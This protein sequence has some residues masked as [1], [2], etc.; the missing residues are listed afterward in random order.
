MLRVRKLV[1]A[2]AAASALTS[3][4]A[5]ALGLGEIALK[6]ALDQPLEAEIELLDVRGLQV[7]ELRSALASVEEFGKVG[8][9]RPYFLTGLKFTPV[10]QANGRSV[11]RVTSDKPVREPYLNFLVEVLWP[12]GRL[13]REYTV[14]L[15]P[16]LYAPAAAAALPSLPVATVAAP[17]PAAQ[18]VQRAAPVSAPAPTP[19]PVAAAR[20][21]LSAPVPPRQPQAAP[22]VARP[23]PVLRAEAAPASVPAS[24]RYRTGRDDTLWK[25]AARVRPSAAV[26]VH[27]TML[28]LQELNP[29]AFV[30]GN[31]NRLKAGQV[32]RL[33]DEQQIRGRSQA[34]ALA[35]V[36]R[37]NVAWR[38]GRGQPAAVARQLDATGRAQPAEPAT[39]APATDKLRLLSADSGTATRGSDK[40]AA[41]GGAGLTDKLALAEEQLATASREN[42]ELNERLGELQSQLD[43]LQRLIELKNAQLARL[44]GTQGE[45]EA[46][47]PPAG[48][49][50]TLAEVAAAPPAEGAAATSPAAAA[51]PAAGAATVAESEPAPGEAAAASAPVAEPAKAAAPDAA[52]MPSAEAPQLLDEL[53][54]NPNLLAAGGGALALL[55]ALGLIAARRRAQR[56][57]SLEA[58]DEP[59][60]LAG[61]GALSALDSAPAVAGAAV[62]AAEDRVL[63]EAEQAIAYGRFTQAAELLRA[64]LDEQPQ[65]SDLRLKLMEVCAE[66]GDRDGFVREEA[67]LRE[68]GGA[69]TQVEQLRS[70]YPSMPAFAAA[71]MA[72]AGVAAAAAEPDA[73]AELDEL[74]LDALSFEMPASEVQ[75]SSDD[76]P[77]AIELTLDDLQ[78]D[79][80]RELAPGG[81]DADL[82][83]DGDAAAPQEIDF[84]LDL[85]ALMLDDNPQSV[86]AAAGAAL[87]PEQVEPELPEMAEPL[88]LDIELPVLAEESAVQETLAGDGL[89]DLQAVDAELDAAFDAFMAHAAQADAMAPAPQ[90]G[91]AT[92][93]DLQFDLS[94]APLGESDLDLPTDADEAATKL[95]LARVYLDMGD[96]EGARDIL[97]EVLREGSAAQQQE[98]RE[99]IGR[100]T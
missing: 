91:R 98:A 6:S 88:S 39:L 97:D 19:A 22:P 69:Q 13:L 63:A 27:Q 32:L 70:R 18:P 90:S 85:D 35:E 53:L 28:A 66:M 41:Q 60:E 20:P 55:L 58:D 67:E 100:M 36:E 52:S 87:L 93:D 1:L 31:I 14:L 61:V 96:V 46:S 10:V 7:A 24:D 30:G 57:A 51:R 23:A 80:E 8:I 89:D 84:E 74:G 95:E 48:A 37:Q 43:K 33:P 3:G 12:N 75:A 5:H 99:L 15:D 56:G 47:E 49:L 72:A 25:I 86:P 76:A 16:P 64:A 62:G 79:L 44:Q 17:L 50:T 92:L 21:P 34:E 81:N 59:A 78:A 77:P 94:A 38:D 82:A 4:L 83:R 40:G 26:S 29:Q 42:Q 65:R 71:G 9:D 2:V 45:A 11:I 73:A 54:A 68:T